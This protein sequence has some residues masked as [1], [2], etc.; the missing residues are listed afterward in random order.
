M[1]YIY[2]GP[3]VLRVNIMKNIESSSVVV[4]WDVVNDFLPTTYTIIWTDERYLFEVATLIEL[5]SYTISGLALDTVYTITVTAANDCGRGSAFST[6]I[7]FTTDTTSTTSSISPTVTA[8][9][10]PII[11]TAN[12]SSTTTTAADTNSSTTSDTVIDPSTTISATIT[13]TNIIRHMTTVNLSTTI[14]P[15]AAVSSFSFSG[16]TTVS[17]YPSTTTITTITTS[18]Y[19]VMSSIPATNFTNSVDVTSKFSHHR[20]NILNNL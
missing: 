6:S 11:S 18:T 10:N 7:L 13:T 19:V 2:T 12:P 16:I 8:S 17:R 20:F 4:Q 15:A 1:F 3:S 14:A 9:T 5:T